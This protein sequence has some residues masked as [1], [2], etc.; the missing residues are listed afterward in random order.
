V[1]GLGWF[2]RSLRA[3]RPGWVPCLAPTA[4]PRLRRSSSARPPDPKTSRI[5]E[6][7]ARMQGSRVLHPGPDP[8]GWSRYNAYGAL[9]AGSSRTP[10]GLARRTRTV[11]QYR[12]V[13]SLSG[14]LPALPGIPRIGL[15]PASTGPLRRPGGSGLAPPLGHTELRGAPMQRL[16]TSRSMTSSPCC[17]A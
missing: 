3:D 16:S 4:S 12:R 10:S 2:P 14:L 7:A 17:P 15:P 8:P 5:P 13:P 9:T 1:G 6:S 11:W